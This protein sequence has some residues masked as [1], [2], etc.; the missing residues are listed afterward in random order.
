[1][2]PQCP[3][4]RG[5]GGK[6][7]FFQNASLLMCYCSFV[8]GQ[9]LTL[10]YQS[11]KQAIA[12]LFK[13]QISPDHPSSNTNKSC[14]LRTYPFCELYSDFNGISYQKLFAVIF[15]IDGNSYQIFLSYTQDRI[16]NKS[17]IKNFK[18]HLR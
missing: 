15:Q 16:F 7:N 8:I 5:D 17:L 12:F 9:F 2:Q 11:E 6:I 3:N 13:V 1:M 4:E 18:C 10:K 14:V